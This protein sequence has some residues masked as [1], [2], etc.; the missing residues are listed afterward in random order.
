MNYGLIITSPQPVCRLVPFSLSLPPAEP[1]L[2][3]PGADA[4]TVGLKGHAGFVKARFAADRLSASEKVRR[5]SAANQVFRFFQ[6]PFIS[7]LIKKAY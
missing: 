3:F 4:E 1:P 2:T 6:A 7:F 5:D